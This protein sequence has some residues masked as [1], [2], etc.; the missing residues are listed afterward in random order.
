M[1][2]DPKAQ[3]FLA[4]ER[5]EGSNTPSPAVTRLGPQTASSGVKRDQMVVDFRVKEILERS[6]SFYQDLM[7]FFIKERNRCSYMDEESVA[8]V[9]LF[10][11]N[12]RE[13]FGSPQNAKEEATWTEEHRKARLYQFDMICAGMQQYFDENKDS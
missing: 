11:I 7:G 12:L 2:L 1:P 6:D 3:N 4:N 9:A 5:L 10:A 8:A 13:A